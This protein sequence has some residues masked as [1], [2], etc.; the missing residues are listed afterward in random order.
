MRAEND[1]GDTKKGD[2]PVILQVHA[3]GKKKS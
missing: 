2:M 3:K 1:S